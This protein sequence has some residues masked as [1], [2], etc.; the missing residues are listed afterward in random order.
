MM[1]WLLLPL[2]V[3]LSAC[4]KSPSSTTTDTPLTNRNVAIDDS[5]LPASETLIPAELSP[6]AQKQVEG[7]N[8]FAFDL[9]RATADEQ[10]DR[11]F[12]PAGITAVLGMAQGGAGGATAIEFQ[13]ALGNDGSDA[14]I[15]AQ[16]EL[17]QK[18]T[19]HVQGR[20][21]S[22]HSALWTDNSITLQ[23]SF[24]ALIRN[25]YNAKVNRVDFINDTTRARKAIN[26][27]GLV[28]TFGRVPELL[29]PQD[30]SKETRLVLFNTAFFRA[31]W[32]SEFNNALTKPK[33]FFRADGSKFDIPM[34]FQEDS[35]PYYKGAGFQMIAM[36][37]MQGETEMLVILP[38]A[39][40]GLPQ[41]E[42]Q[43]NAAELTKWRT[44]MKDDQWPEVE[45]SFPKFTRK[46][47]QHFEGPLK[48]LGFETAFDST[49]ADMSRM[50]VKS[51][52]GPVFLS[53]LVHEAVIE[54]D[55]EGT[56]AAAATALVAVA[57]SAE[58]GPPPKPKIFNADHPFLFLI[59]DVRTGLILFMGRFTG[60]QQG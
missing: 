19:Y 16:G 31:R 48:K 49:R 5:K 44:A 39:R 24:E 41:L 42:R 51:K 21:L 47:R 28:T 22:T 14:A 18:M 59:R 23:P 55:E 54:I 34:M 37:Y 6:A 12:S 7:Y 38:D 46:Q 1:R 2:L 11:F 43:L 4:D 45:L 9:Y 8:T 52:S 33:P 20:T 15:K 26:Q 40:D 36:R 53:K 58:T 29:G 57:A 56:V 25:S 60:T 13:K 10:G 3:S 32:R 30:L 35:F 27:R 50:V 17:L